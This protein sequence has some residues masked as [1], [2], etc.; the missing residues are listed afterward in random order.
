LGVVAAAAITDTP[1]TQAILFLNFIA[2]TSMIAV[3]DIPSG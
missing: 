3:V 1:S 2:V